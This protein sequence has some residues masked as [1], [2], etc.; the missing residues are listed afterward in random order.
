MSPARSQATNN[1]NGFMPAGLTGLG[2]GS[3]RPW[4]ACRKGRPVLFRY[5]ACFAD[6]LQHCLGTE[7]DHEPLVVRPSRLLKCYPE[8]LVRFRRSVD[9]FTLVKPVLEVQSTR[10]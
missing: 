2:C 7:H 8:M 5:N 10:T 6:R 1:T 4:R 9:A 3:G